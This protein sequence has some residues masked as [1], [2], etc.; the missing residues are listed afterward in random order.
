MR[1]GEP[2]LYKK[3]SVLKLVTREMNLVGEW[4]ARWG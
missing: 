1:F 2:E 3:P 4:E